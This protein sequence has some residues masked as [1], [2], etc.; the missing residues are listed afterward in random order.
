MTEELVR[1]ELDG[2][3]A[4]LT[5]QRPDAANAIDLALARALHD[6]ALRCDEDPTVRAVVLTGTGRMFCA[7]GDLASFEQAGVGRPKLIKEITTY[8][9]AAVARFAR[10]R[11]P[12]VAAVNGAAAGAGLALVAAAD[13]AVASEQAKFTLAYTRAGLTPDGSS[14]WFLP[15]LVGTRRSLELMLTNRVLSAAEALDWGIVNRVVPA[16]AVVGEAESLAREL[17]AGATEAFGATK[18]LLL[19]SGSQGLE[20]QMEIEARAIA[21]AARSADAAEGIAAFL[22][23][24][25]PRFEG[26]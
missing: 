1:F 19:L 24:R 26:R 25:A 2:A 7:G 16:A 22:A 13:L 6:A 20:T 14:T 21:D 17:A 10:M 11:A 18:R 9:H 12:V 8:L 5:L 4:R 3:L 15:R 23:K